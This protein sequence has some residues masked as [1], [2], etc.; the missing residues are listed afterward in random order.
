M[1]YDQTNFT[2]EDTLTQIGLGYFPVFCLAMWLPQKHYWTALA[3]VLIGFWAAYAVSPPAPQN[4]DYP[5][6]GVPT[7]W[8]HHREGFASR[9]NKNSNLSWRFD[10]W[11]L[12][13]FPRESTFEYNR[14][15]YA[16]LS[17]IPTMG[18]M[19]IGLIAGTWMRGLPTFRD[20][21][22]RLLVVGGVFIGVALLLTW[23]GVCP[24]VKRIWTPA[25]ALYSGGFCLLALAG[26][27]WI[28][29]GMG[30]QRWAFL[31]VVIG[32]NSILIYV[33]S[34][35]VADPLREMLLRHFG[36]RT[37]GLLGESLVPLTSGAA[38]M[39]VMIAALWWL[40]RQRVFIR[41]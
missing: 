10:V 31:F 21:L 11:F 12:N 20:R 22:S 2:F 23:S 34:W 36:T 35:T 33:M 5:A 26:L 30:M 6:V 24:N 18:T 40:Y 27:H 28:C 29:D 3:V 38:T 1:D 13:L 4:F 41:I 25:F 17:F 15:G 7:D 37:F 32:A 19:L 9:F 39:A 8:P 14:G 16:T